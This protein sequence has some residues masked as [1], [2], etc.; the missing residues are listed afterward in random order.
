[1]NTHYVLYRVINTKTFY[2]EEDKRRMCL[3]TYPRY[4]GIN[5]ATFAFKHVSQQQRF[6]V[7]N[8]SRFTV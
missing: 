2:L 6:C 8:I 4:K 1:M 3:R 7:R 5:A